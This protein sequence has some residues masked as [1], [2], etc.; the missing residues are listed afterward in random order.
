MT[1][2]VTKEN[3]KQILNKIKNEINGQASSKYSIIEGYFKTVN[4]SKLFGLKCKIYEYS[5]RYEVYSNLE[6]SLSFDKTLPDSKMDRLITPTIYLGRSYSS[7]KSVLGDYTDYAKVSFKL[8]A[9]YFVL[10]D[11]TSKNVTSIY[12][13]NN[14]SHYVYLGTLYKL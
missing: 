2:F 10:D 9:G 7:W 11:N 1:K 6:T 14:T 13:T 4:G 12:F 3:L 8:G 5:D